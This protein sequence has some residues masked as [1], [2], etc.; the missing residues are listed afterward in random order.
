MLLLLLSGASAFSFTTMPATMPAVLK[1]RWSPAPVAIVD[2]PT[3]SLFAADAP[4]MADGAG[5]VA[6]AGGIVMILTAGIPILF[7]RGDKKEDAASK[8]AGLEQGVGSME[9]VMDEIYE[10][11]AP[12]PAADTDKQRGTI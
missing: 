3:T 6:A 7:L 5:L 4:V 11:E 9:E 12:A 8:L 2:M 10:E 1:T